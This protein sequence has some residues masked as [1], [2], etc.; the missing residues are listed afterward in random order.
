MQRFFDILLSGIAIAILAPVLLLIM[1]VLKLTGEGEVFYFQQR[2]G[3]GGKPF[4]VFKFTTMRKKSETT[5]TGLITTRNDPR[6]LPVGRFLRK[7]KLNELPQIINIFIGDM[8]VVGPRPQVPSHFDYY[9]TEVKTELNK[10]RPGLTGIG[11]IVFRDEESILEN[12]KTLSYDECYSQL[13]APYKG[14]LELWYI[15]HKSI[16]LY[17][18]L[19]F[20]TAWVVLFSDHGTRLTSIF[21]DLPVPPP[22]LKL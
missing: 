22:E 5:G 16:W 15:E 13:I 4:G 19:I 14:K 17:F 10:I 7:T 20:V 21:K 12:N 18:K 2:V 11:S 9:S 8:S 3:R 1:L 6:V